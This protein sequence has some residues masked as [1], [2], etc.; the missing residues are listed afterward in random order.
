MNSV[1]IPE[2][3][4]RPLISRRKRFLFILITF[5][6]VTLF[7][8]LASQVFY[9]VSVGR[10]LWQWW[11]VPIFTEDPV[12]VYRVKSNLNYLHKTSE[13]TARYCTDE[14]GMLAE[15]G[16]AAPPIAKSNDTFRILAF[17]PSFAFGWGVNYEEAY[18]NR[19]AKELRV[20]G[21]RVEL[22]NLGT[23]SQPPCY[24][25]KWLKAVGYQYQPDLIVQTCYGEPEAM[26]SDDTLPTPRPGVKNGYLYPSEKMTASMWA[27]RMRTYSTLLFY[28]WHFYNVVSRPNVT[29]AEG[30]EFYTKNVP[31]HAI[32]NDDVQKYV[33]YIDFVQSVVTNKPQVIFLFVPL[34]HVVRP[35][36][37]TR[38]AHHGVTDPFTVRENTKWITSALGS[39]HVHMINLTD[40]LVEHDKSTRMYNLYDIHFTAAGNKVAADY[41]LPIIQEIIQSQPP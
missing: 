38:V 36:D 27:R 21:K 30:K 17:G 13:F 31:G 32:S 33:R 23:P 19:I 22:I 15:P 41:S 34:S 40:V 5:V 35:A 18:M 14:F 20:P 11:A 25:L 3:S 29:A 37:I 8:E 7:A 12:R 1:S 24:Q 2:R 26:D 9:R 4:R 10:W 16:R 6:L 28:G 39:N